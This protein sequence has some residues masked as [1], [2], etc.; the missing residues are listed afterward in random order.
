M[1]SSAPH[2]AQRSKTTLPLGGI[3]LLKIVPAKGDGDGYVSS[4]VRVTLGL[5]PFVRPGWI[6]GWRPPSASTA[7]R[8]S[9]V[10]GWLA[11][12][13]TLFAS[14]LSCCLETVSGARSLE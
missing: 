9:R 14:G 6:Q 5:G 12:I 8:P 1:N 11:P 3:S 10:V 4:R 13:A 2:T 7:I